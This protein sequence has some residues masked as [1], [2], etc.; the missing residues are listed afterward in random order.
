MSDWA[1]LAL[2]LPMGDPR[3]ST[4]SDTARLAFLLPKGE[5][6]AE[7]KSSVRAKLAL[8]LPEGDLGVPTAPLRFRDVAAWK[9]S[10]IATLLMAREI[11]CLF[12]QNTVA[13]YQSN[14]LKIRIATCGKFVWSLSS[15]HRGVRKSRALVRCQLAGEGGDYR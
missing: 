11:L 5:A 1:K 15:E 8:L 7:S 13:G 12:I 2:L 14:W 3:K 4:L 10:V 6:F 9:S